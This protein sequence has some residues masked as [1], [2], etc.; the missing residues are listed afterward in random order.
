[1]FYFGDEVVFIGDDSMIFGMEDDD[2]KSLTFGETYTIYDCTND[3]CIVLDPNTPAYD[4]ECFV[5]HKQYN[6]II[7]KQKLNK[8]CSK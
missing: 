7:R 2:D 6:K 1:M 8:I 5:T 3:Y 4:A